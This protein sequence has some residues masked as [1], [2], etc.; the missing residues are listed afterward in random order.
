MGTTTAGVP[1][2][3]SRVHTACTRLLLPLPGTPATPTSQGDWLLQRSGGASGQWGMHAAAQTLQWCGRAGRQA[4][5]QTSR[6]ALGLVSEG[7][8]TAPAAAPPLQRLF[9]S[10]CQTV[11]H[12]LHG[13]SPAQHVGC[14]CLCCC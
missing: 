2:A 5:R 11:V 1:R 8:S 14:C 7:P 13:S 3:L 12:L 4:G 9:Y 10:V 6:Q